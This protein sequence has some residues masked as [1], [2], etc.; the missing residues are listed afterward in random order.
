MLGLNLLLLH[1]TTRAAAEKLMDVEEAEDKWSSYLI[2]ASLLRRVIIAYR[3][4][5][6]VTSEFV[7]LHKA[8]NAV[9]FQARM[10]SM[11]AS[12][13]ARLVPNICLSIVASLVGVLVIEGIV[14]LSTFVVFFNTGTQ[15]CTLIRVINSS[16]INLPFSFF[17]LLLLISVKSFGPTLGAIYKNVFVIGESYANI[18]NLAKL[19]NADTRRKMLHRAQLRRI[20]LIEHSKKDPKNGWDAKH[21]I[22][23]AVSHRFPGWFL[24]LSAHVLSEQAGRSCCLAHV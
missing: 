20:D 12:Q 5:Y 7:R 14:T 24:L 1:L 10:Y 4:G 3:K 23:D 11:S 17:L 22:V 2:Q 21:L 6:K 18:K 16:F 13:L 9:A 8:Y 19:L 15:N